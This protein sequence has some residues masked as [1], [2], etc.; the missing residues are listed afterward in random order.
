MVVG[1]FSKLLDT[2]KAETTELHIHIPTGVQV[3]SNCGMTSLLKGEVQALPEVT[4]PPLDPILPTPQLAALPVEAGLE[5]LV[6]AHN[7]PTP[8]LLTQGT[9][10]CFIIAFR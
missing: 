3:V 2:G 5:V 10:K 8:P 9:L 6:L 4:L 7:L 1:P